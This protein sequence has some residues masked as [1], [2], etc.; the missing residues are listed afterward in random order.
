MA[1]TS[2]TRATGRGGSADTS[3]RNVLRAAWSDERAAARSARDRGDVATE[4]KHLERAH[5]LSQPLAG[6]HVRTHLAMLAHAF[7]RRDRHEVVGQ[8]LRVIVAGP[9]SWT[10][11]YPVGNTGGA[12]VSAFRPMPVPDDLQAILE[13]SR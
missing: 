10:G 9:G 6:A 3:G 12:D 13:S 2:T 7:R 4:W 11:R 8:L 5:I 1:R